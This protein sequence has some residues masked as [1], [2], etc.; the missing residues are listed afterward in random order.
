M[1][2]T[3]YVNGIATPWIG[4]I[5]HNASVSLTATLRGTNG[6]VPTGTVYLYASQEGCINNTGGQAEGLSDG[7]ATL[8]FSGL[9][10]GNW[11]FNATYNGDSN[12]GRLI[13]ATGL[14]V[15][16]LTCPYVTSVAVQTQVAFNSGGGAAVYPIS[17]L[18]G[19]SIRLPSDTYPGYAF[20]GWFTAASGGTRVGGADSS[21][22]IPSGGIN[23]YAQWS[24][25]PTTSPSSLREG[26]RCGSDLPRR[27]RRT[28]PASNSCSSGAATVLGDLYATLT[29]YGW[30]C[31]W[32]TTAVPDGTYAV[33]SYAAGVGGTASS[34]VVSGSTTT[35]ASRHERSHPFER[36][37]LV[38][39]DHLTPPHRTPPASGSCSSAAATAI[40][41]SRCAPLGQRS[42]GGCAPGTRRRCPTAITPWCHTPP[43]RRE[44][45]LARALVSRSETT[46]PCPPRAFCRAAGR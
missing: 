15:P 46:L 33:V 17:G 10:D 39:S 20:N 8:G 34:S 3:L 45:Q 37:D 27:F 44:P 29:L 22:I 9:P 38:G 19:S 11:F 4:T 2:F 16:P 42:T 21:Y 23:L 26:R 18:D 41:A 35:T 13:Y 6:V 5:P 24:V 7:V 31:A 12:Y 36:G 43:I 28:P 32:N 25:L 40:P 14:F 30:L 1:D